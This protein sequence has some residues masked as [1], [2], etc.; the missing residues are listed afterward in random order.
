VRLSGQKSRRDEGLGNDIG[1]EGASLGVEC[2]RQ[3]GVAGTI[4]GHDGVKH[5]RLIR[6]PQNEVKRGTRLRIK[7]LKEVGRVGREKEQVERSTQRPLKGVRAHVRRA[8]VSKQGQG[9]PWTARRQLLRH[10]VN[11]LTEKLGVDK[12]GVRA[13]EEASPRPTGDLGGALEGNFDV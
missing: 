5:V 11:N 13:R 10:Q 6:R 7:E 9:Q 4:S 3:K 8:L 2:G 1:R 12:S